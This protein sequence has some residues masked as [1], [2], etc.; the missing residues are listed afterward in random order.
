M[1]ALLLYGGILRN[2]DISGI[3]HAM[4][5]DLSIGANC[6]DFAIL[7]VAGGHVIGNRLRVFGTSEQFRRAAA[8]AAA[9]FSII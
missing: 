7:F 1:N 9:L 5:I 8:A 3:F 6:A 2:C 4:A